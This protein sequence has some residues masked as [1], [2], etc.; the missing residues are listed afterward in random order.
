MGPGTPVEEILASV[1]EVWQLLETL[2]L[3][4]DLEIVCWHLTIFFHSPVTLFH[5]SLTNPLRS[6]QNNCLCFT[7]GNQRKEEVP[8]T[9]GGG[10]GPCC[11]RSP[12]ATQDLVF[13]KYFPHVTCLSFM[14]PGGLGGEAH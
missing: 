1:A 2:D 14:Q 5:L 7:D 9:M 4:S 12:P 13:V 3:E 6:L 10:R 11:L 8:R